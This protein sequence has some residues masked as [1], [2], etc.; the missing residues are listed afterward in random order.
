G[1]SQLSA[2][3]T[4]AFSAYDRPAHMALSLLGCLLQQ[5]QFQ[6]PAVGHRAWL[7]FRFENL[8]K[9]VLGKDDGVFLLGGI[10]GG[11]AHVQQV[12]TQGQVRAVLLQ[13]AEGEQAGTLRP[14]DAVAELGR[15][16]LLPMHRQLVLSRWRLSPCDRDTEC[17]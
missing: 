3:P 8:P 9:V 10:E 15:R 1:S 11:V 2:M 6:S 4:F 16:Q 13:N 14:G 5:L 17:V 12:V 7:M